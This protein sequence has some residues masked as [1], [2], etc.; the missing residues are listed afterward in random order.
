MRD[1]VK[2]RTSVL[3]S[4]YQLL[5]LYSSPYY[6]PVL[7]A[8]Y[9]LMGKASI[10]KVPM[11]TCWGKTP[12]GDKYPRGMFGAVEESEETAVRYIFTTEFGKVGLST[13]PINLD[14]ELI[15]LCPFLLYC[16]ALK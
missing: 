4:I 11:V 8:L 15:Q 14:I 5:S 7:K 1:P 3:A 16:I 9:T 10:R 12:L 13:Q 6:G 2:W